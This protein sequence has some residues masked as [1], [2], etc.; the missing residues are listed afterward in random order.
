MSVLTKTSRDDALAAT[1]RVN[2]KPIDVM[3]DNLRFWYDAATGLTDQIKAVLAEADPAALAA[4]PELLKDLNA[5]IKNMLFARERAQEC[6]V[7]MAPYRHPRLANIEVH[8]GFGED[9]DKGQL[10]ITH[11][12]D[13]KAAARAYEESLRTGR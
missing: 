2:L 7:D 12:L 3:A 5:N 4:Q 11:K 1:A 8:T 9:D 13:P 6:A 10:K